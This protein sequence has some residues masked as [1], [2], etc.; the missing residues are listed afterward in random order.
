M[1]IKAVIMWALAALSLVFTGGAEALVKKTWCGEFYYTAT[2]K[3][4]LHCGGG[5]V[6][7]NC[8]TSI[9]WVLTYGT[10]NPDIVQQCDTPGCPCKNYYVPDYLW[11]TWEEMGRSLSLPIRSYVPHK[12][13]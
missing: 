5:C 1:R 10:T 12:R 13:N 2:I 6:A 3:G 8:T 4:E 7:A 9:F 11:E